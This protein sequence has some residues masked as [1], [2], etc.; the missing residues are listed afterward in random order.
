VL[1]IRCPLGHALEIGPEHFGQR[2]MCPICQAVVYAALPRAGDKPTAK[3][4]LQCSH[5]HILRVKQKYLN[6]EVTCPSCSEKV[7]MK[8]ENV[9]A[10]SGLTLGISAPEMVAKYKQAVKAKQAAKR[11]ERAAAANTQGPGGRPE[12]MTAPPGKMPTPNATTN[13]ASLEKGKPLPP[14]LASDEFEVA[15]NTPSTPAMPAPAGNFEIEI[16]DTQFRIDMEKPVAPSVSPRQ[17][18]EPLFAAGRIPPPPIRPNESRE[19]GTIELNIAPDQGAAK[20]VHINCPNGHVLSIEKQYVGQK[21][22]CPLCQ[23]IIDTAAVAVTEAPAAQPSTIQLKCP[24]GHLLEIDRQYVGMQ[25]QC[26]LCQSVLDVPK[27]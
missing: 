15:A 2:L 26:P 14:Y 25:V 10:F 6:K 20:E 27:S 5:G 18:P 1:H 8:P 23:T 4:E 7:P 16:V 13:W 17:K 3:Y 21:I 11:A 19:E 12:T 24:K 9:M 22:Q